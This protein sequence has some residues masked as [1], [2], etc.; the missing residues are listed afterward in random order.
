MGNI[1]QHTFTLAQY[2]YTALS[3]LRYPNGSP[4][5]RIYCDSKFSSPDVQG[6]VINFNVLD[7]NG[8]IIGYSQVGFLVILLACSNRIALLHISVPFWALKFAVRGSCSSCDKATVYCWNGPWPFLIGSLLS[9]THSSNKHG[10]LVFQPSLFSQKWSISRGKREV[11]SLV[12]VERDRWQ[13]GRTHQNR[14]D[15]KAV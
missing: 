3:A 6:P 4:V 9:F 14:V 15:R 8:K 2:T 5:V 11:E 10:Y 7:D 13:K 12:A 1:Q